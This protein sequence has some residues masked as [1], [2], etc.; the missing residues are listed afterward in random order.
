M[1]QV[2]AQAPFAICIRNTGYPAALELRKIYAVL[3]DPQAA[4]HHLVRIIDESGEDYLYPQ[5]YFIL[6]DFPPVVAE[7]LRTAA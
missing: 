5:D 2:V 3:P 7:A 6:T 1:T 4:A